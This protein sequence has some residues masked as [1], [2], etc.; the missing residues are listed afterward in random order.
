MI[1]ITGLVLVFNLARRANWRALLAR[2]AVVGGF[3]AVICSYMWL[4][5]IAQISFFGASPY[6]QRWKYDS[7]GAS[8]ILWWLV[9]GDLFDHGRWPVITVILARESRLL[10]FSCATAVH[11]DYLYAFVVW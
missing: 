7:F 10:S 1:V 6:L 8:D 4:P 2:L 9:N 3:T 11:R 5:F